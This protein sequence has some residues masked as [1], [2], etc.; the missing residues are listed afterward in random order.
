MAPK[1][2]YPATLSKAMQRMY[3]AAQ[4]QPGQPQSIAHLVVE[5]TSSYYILFGIPKVEVRADIVEF[6]SGER[7]P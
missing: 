4:M 2:F 3:A 6:K 1:L 7:R 5:Q